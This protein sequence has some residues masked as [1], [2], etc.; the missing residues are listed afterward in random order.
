V[1]IEFARSGHD[2]QMAPYPILRYEAYRR[3]DAPP[4]AGY[5][6]R[7]PH[8]IGWTQV[9]EVNAHQ[10]LG[11]SIVVPTIGDST[12]ALGPYYSTFFIRAATDDPG[13]FYD[14]PPDSGYSIDNLAP[15]VPAGLAYNTGTLTW[16]ES[17]AEDF[18]YF[19]VYGANTQSFGSATLVDY[20]VEPTM[21]ITAA[22]Y[23]FY[24]VTATD[25]SGNEGSA[26]MINTLSGVGGTP[27]D[28]VLSVSAYPNPFNP[29]TTV[30]YTLPSRGHVTVAVYDARGA[31]VAT[32]AD[33]DQ[34]A[35]AYTERWDGHDG[36]GRA[37][38]SGVY[39]ARVDHP[40]GTKAY[41]M[42]LLK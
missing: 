8:A 3:I 42:V 28:Y 22:G 36:A 25:F 10:E 32:L 34:D 26:A 29:S 40:A 38:S 5:A 12:V 31:R 4:S 16:D 30:R 6:V 17:R 18:D 39:F 35:G 33:A 15:G 19:T 23:V 41:K 27:K 9:G 1:L 20:C 24:F 2:D 7:E 13:I 14:S 37:V 11:Y 21:D